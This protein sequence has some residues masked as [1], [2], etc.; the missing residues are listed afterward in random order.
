M[1]AVYIREFGGPEKI[2][3]GQIDEPEAG[4]GEVRV[5]VKA[6][7][8]NHLDVWVRKGRPGLE[9]KG[10]HVLGSDAAGVVDAVGGGVEG[11]AVG[12]EV[13]I[14]AGVSCGKCEFCRRGDQSECPDFKL[15]GFQRPGVY[16]EKAV[17]PS[18]NVGPKPKHLTWEEAAALPLAHLTAWHMLFP[19]ARFQ[20]GESVLIHGIGG[21]VALAALQLVRMNGGEAIVTSSSEEKLAKAKELGASAGVNYRNTEDVGAAVKDLTGGRG[22]DIAFDTVGAPT[23]PVSPQ[24]TMTRR[25]TAVFHPEEIFHE[26]VRSLHAAVDRCRLRKSGTGRLAG[27]DGNSNEACPP[28]RYAG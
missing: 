17:V 20:A 16:A 19:R 8:L 3:V 23:L 6:A 21:G 25:T 5:S 22:V 24:S 18:C 28:R 4:C 13:V 1:R 9:L 26:S 14:N 15:L 11:V 12:D 2:Q 27:L 10:P 7:A